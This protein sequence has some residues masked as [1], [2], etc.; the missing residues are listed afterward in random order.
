MLPAANAAR[1][2]SRRAIARRRKPRRK[3]LVHGGDA[4]WPMEHGVIAVSLPE[5]MR[6][7]AG[8]RA[9]RR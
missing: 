4:T 1:H 3:F 8:H 9:R 2:P 6:R 7:L 5:L